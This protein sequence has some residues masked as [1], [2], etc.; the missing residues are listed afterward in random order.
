MALRP[1]LR[2][3]R[4]EDRELQ[5]NLD[6][7]V[8]ACVKGRTGKTGRKEKRKMCVYQREDSK[9]VGALTRKMIIFIFLSH[10]S[11]LLKEKKVTHL[12]FCMC[13]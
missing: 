1:A 12:I 2:K 8:R 13:V 4:Q 9:C 5:A 6:Y 3:L 11:C 10:T 7:I